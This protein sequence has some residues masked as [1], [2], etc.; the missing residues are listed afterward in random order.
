MN[1]FAQ[2]YID[3]INQVVADLSG[4]LEEYERRLVSARK[5]KEQKVQ[6]LWAVMREANAMRETLERMPALEDENERLQEKN[7]EMLGRVR[8]ILEYAKALS[9]AAER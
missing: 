8:R 1:P 3:Q 6:E 5:A 9:G 2:N 7:R 4:T